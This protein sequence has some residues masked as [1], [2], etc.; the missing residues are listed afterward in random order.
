ML[1]LSYFL[2]TRPFECKKENKHEIFNESCVLASCYIFSFF[3]NP[4]LPLNFRNNLGL[5]LVAICIISILTNIVLVFSSSL[6]EI[7]LNILN[8]RKSFVL[9]RRIKIKMERRKLLVKNFEL[10][11]YS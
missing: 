10:K 7:W 8:Y 2:G 9:K 5:V 11:N 6:K 3:L 4:T 1:Q